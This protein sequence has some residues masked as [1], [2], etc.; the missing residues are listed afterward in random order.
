MANES[1]VQPAL[2]ALDSGDLALRIVA[3]RRLRAYTDEQNHAYDLGA[4]TLDELRR[5]R[6]LTD[7]QILPKVLPLLRDE[8]AEIRR[9]AAEVLGKNGGSGV[10][11]ALIDALFDPDAA[12]RD[13]VTDAL[14]QLGDHA[15]VPALIEAL[16]D[17]NIDVRFGAAEA[18]RLLADPRAVVDLIHVLDNDDTPMAAMAAMAL[19]EIGTPEAL[20]AIQH[21]REGDRY[22]F[23]L[24]PEDVQP[25]ETIHHVP[26]QAETDADAAELESTIRHVPAELLEDYLA[27]EADEAAATQ[28]G[29][30][31]TAEPDAR[32]PA[33]FSAYYPREVTANAWQPL[34]AYVFLP[35]AATAVAADA[36]QELGALLPT[37]REVERTSSVGIAEG[38]LITATPELAGFQF[39]PPSAQVGFFEDWQRF[40]FRLRASAAPL[41]QASNGRITFHVEGLIVADIPLSIYVGA[42]ARAGSTPPLMTSPRP[43]YQSIFCSYSHQDT[44]IV[45]RVERAYKALGLTFLRDVITLR[46]GQDWDDELLRLIDNADIFQLFW[47]NAASASAAVRK[48]WEHAL[49]LKRQDAA[50]IRPVY[51][52]QPMPPPAPELAAI[53]FAYEPELGQP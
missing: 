4:I 12:V 19:H 28:P 6:T 2:L 39:N 49:S 7:E 46:S 41:D 21:L 37:Y 52:Q 11:Q 9:L 42:A 31:V 44:Q 15:A 26:A 32:N 30:P 47:S 36:V 34:R 3:L 48:E 33:Q 1:D 8:N 40:D 51:W 16:Y 29:R 43:I 18:L 13:A 27:A 50:F 17:A 38:A 10:V 14:G 5:S 45:E 25:E 24:F 22:H 23:E 53:H 20:A 35:G